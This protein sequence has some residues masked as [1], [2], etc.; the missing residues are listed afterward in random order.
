[1]AIEDRKSD[2]PLIQRLL[3]EPYTFSF[4][5]AVYI[6]EKYSSSISDIRYVGNTGPVELE[7][8]RF[9][10]DASLAFPVSDIVSIEKTRN[11]PPRFEITTSFLGL[12]GSDS[13]LPDFYTKIL[14]DQILMNLM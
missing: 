7:S 5:K 6:V 3:K 10:P 1:M 8:I 2:P 11:L 12:Y 14:L 4:F 13:P 9:K